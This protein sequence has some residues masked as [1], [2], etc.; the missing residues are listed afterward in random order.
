MTT[1]A[2]VAHAVGALPNMTRSQGER[3]AAFIAE[4]DIRDVLELGFRHGVSTAYLAAAL[5]N[6]GGGRITTIDRL[7]ARDHQPN[8]ENLLSKVGERDRV[9]VFYEPTSYTWRLMRMLQADPK[10]RF[11]LCYIDGA[12]DWFVDGLAFFL[13]DRLL[14]PGGWLLLDDLNWTFEGSRSLKHNERVRRMP[15]DE[16]ATPQVRL[17]YEL[18]VKP[19]PGYHNLRVEGEWAFA[20]KT[21]DADQRSPATLDTEVVVVERRVGPV[22]AVRGLLRRIPKTSR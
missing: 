19:H 4:H 16:R 18:L 10:P 3:I 14:R 6:A 11:D 15:E 20:Q 7:A 5:G 17:V 12:H 9:D 1:V 21:D 13:A 22:Y 8:V 2:Q